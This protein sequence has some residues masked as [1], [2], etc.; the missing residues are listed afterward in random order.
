L[1]FDEIYNVSKKLN[2]LMKGKEKFSEE[3]LGEIKNLV[4]E[5][6]S[7]KIEPIK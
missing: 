2:V 4:N 3:E 6:T 1:K 7:I 5:I